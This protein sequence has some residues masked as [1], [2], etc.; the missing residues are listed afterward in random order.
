[1]GQGWGKL[2]Y[3]ETQPGAQSVTLPDR[4]KG[5]YQGVRKG[6]TL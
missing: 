3:W 5:H 4:G 1:M 2:S 6:G